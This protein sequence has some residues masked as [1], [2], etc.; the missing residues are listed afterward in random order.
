MRKFV[1]AVPVA[2]AVL[3][4]G[5]S[6][7]PSAAKRHAGTGLAHS[8]HVGDTLNLTNKAGRL[9]TVT[10]SKVIDPAQGAP[11]IVPK[12]G[13]RFV[14]VVF[15]IHNS[16][17]Q[18]ISPNVITDT[19]VIGSSG[20]LYPANGK[21]LSSCAAFAHQQFKLEPGSSASGCV[22]FQIPT[23]VT[24][25]QVQFLPTGGTANDYGQWL[26]P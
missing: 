12:T 19:I 23:A 26:N 4:A 8:G 21:M 3:I 25:S 5:C 2:L 22:T 20:K 6:S 1:I 13:K 18:S 24:V 7:S 10:L 11:G 14:G 17:S 15:T 9:F 16:A